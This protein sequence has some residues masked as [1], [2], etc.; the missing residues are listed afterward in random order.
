MPDTIPLAPL[1]AALGIMLGASLIVERFLAVF[2]WVIDRLYLLWKTA[3]LD[4]GKALAAKTM[5]LEAAHAESE[6]L[7]QT[8]GQPDTDPV[9]IP[10]RDTTRPAVEPFEITDEKAVIKEFWLQL[11]GFLVGAAA[12]YYT[13]FSMWQLFDWLPGI[14][15]GA[16]Q[17]WEYFL[18]GIVIGAGSKPV[19][20]LMKFLLE[21]KLEKPA[22]GTFEEIVPSVDSGPLTKNLQES[23]QKQETPWTPESEWE[24]YFG[25]TY[26]GGYKPERLEFTHFR[27]HPIDLIVVHHT[28]MHSDSPFEAIV[29]EFQRKNWLAGY[30]TIVF[31]DGAVRTFTRWDRIGSHVKGYNYRSLGIAFHGNFEPDPAVPFSNPDGRLGIMT[32]TASQLEA[33]ARVIALWV[34]MYRIPLDF[35]NNIVPHRQLAPKACPGGNFPL[36]ALQ[37]RVTQLVQQ[38]QSDKAVLTALDQFKSLAYIG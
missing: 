24:K 16:P 17:L 7:Q 12:C 29:E 27:K 38:W 9:E 13:R 22:S 37:E 19:H 36:Q 18:T 20:F 26:D 35:N 10:P 28:A 32:P 30:H 14:Q 34:L 21:R 25:F 2:A 1:L 11:L 4:V 15:K 3:T 23:N 5:Q 33:G 6:L 31:K 8:E